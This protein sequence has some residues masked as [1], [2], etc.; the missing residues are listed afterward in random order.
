[1]CLEFRGEIREGMLFKCLIWNEII[2]EASVDKRE[3]R[4]K[5]SFGFF[6]IFS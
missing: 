6:K 2:K 1:M 3:R 4:S 5:D